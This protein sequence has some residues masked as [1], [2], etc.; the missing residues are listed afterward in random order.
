MELTMTISVAVIAAIMV[1]G[2]LCLIPV[3]FQI[4]RTAQQVE[5]ALE[6]VRMQIVPVSHDVTIISQEVNGIIRSIHRQVD[7][8]E[9][10]V[11]T[12]RDG[13]ERLREFEEDMVQRIEEPLIEMATLLSA[14]TRGVETFFRLLLR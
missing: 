2:V 11:T 14:V 5:K 3:L 7:K 13:A 12:V 4:R 9:D 6:T 10:G 8:I 1:A